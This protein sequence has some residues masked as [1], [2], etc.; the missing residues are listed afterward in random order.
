MLRRHPHA[1]RR[2]HLFRQ[3]RRPARLAPAGRDRHP[4][5][6]G[7]R[8][9]HPREDPR[10]PGRRQGRLRG[11][12]LR[13]HVPGRTS[14]ARGD[15]RLADRSRMGRRPP[16]RWRANTTPRSSRSTSPAR[17]RRLFHLFDRV[18]QE[19]RDI[20]LFHEL[21]NKRSK[22]FR[23]RASASRSRRRG[24][25]STRPA[26]PMALK[27]FIERVLPAQPDAEFA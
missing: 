6:M 20:T 12:T 1:A 16:P 2:R 17:T 13:R 24:S 19:L 8:Q 9:T 7:R 23:P 14:G 15:G 10:H 21:L 5:R 26:P 22:P 11:R 25:T 3:R 4:G 18:S 27:A